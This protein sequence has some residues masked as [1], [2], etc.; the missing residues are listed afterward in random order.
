MMVGRKHV[1]L[2]ISYRDGR[3]RLGYLY[4]SEP[5]EKSAR[6]RRISA[7]LVID[8]N[9]DGQLIGIEL[10][11]PEHTTLEAINEVLKQH[12]VEPVQESDLKPILAA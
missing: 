3:P 11:D 8:L 1:D 6:S 10:L 7:E 9:Q 4:L 12:G 2:E 5:G